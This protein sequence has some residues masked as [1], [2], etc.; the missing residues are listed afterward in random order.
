LSLFPTAEI[1]LFFPDIET[2]MIFRS[3]CIFSRCER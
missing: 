3:S 2:S 1:F